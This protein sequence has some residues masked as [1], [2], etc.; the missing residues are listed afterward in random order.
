MNYNI[1]GI[2]FNFYRKGA[3]YSAGFETL[4][5]FLSFE[6]IFEF[7]DMIDRGRVVKRFSSQ[8]SAF[9]PSLLT[10]DD[11][12]MVD[13][14]ARLLSASFQNFIRFVATRYASISTK[15]G[16]SHKISLHTKSVY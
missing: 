2:D 3:K 10:E 11:S 1:P 7:Q 9:L 16:N 13:I 4:F 12:K 5:Y 15:G 6:A 14:S 8:I